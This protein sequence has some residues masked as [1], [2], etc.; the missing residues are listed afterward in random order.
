[1]TLITTEYIV[2]ICP[3]FSIRKREFINYPVNFV[4]TTANVVA[5]RI[6]DLIF[7]A[8]LFL[9]CVTLFIRKYGVKVYFAT[10]KLM[11]ETKNYFTVNVLIYIAMMRVKTQGT[12]SLLIIFMLP[13][14]NVLIVFVHTRRLQF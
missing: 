3:I 7:K 2:F 12:S 4:I 14:L 1:M 11:I 10:H 5:K 8:K 13:V 9:I 6:F